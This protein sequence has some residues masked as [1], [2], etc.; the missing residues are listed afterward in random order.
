MSDSAVNLAIDA[1][2]EWTVEQAL[3][4]SEFKVVRDRHC[5]TILAYTRCGRAYG[6]PINCPTV[7]VD[8]LGAELI[9]AAK[10]RDWKERIAP[11]PRTAAGQRV[12]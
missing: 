4:V 1:I 9:E 11:P 10:A 3:V 8:A 5:V 12:H 6:V 7:I 2:L